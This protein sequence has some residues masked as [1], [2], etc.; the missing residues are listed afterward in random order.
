MPYAD[1]EEKKARNRAY[2]A[3]N[4]ERILAQQRE[5]YAETAA[6]A[7][8]QR[9]DYYGR[10]REQAVARAKRWRLGNRERHNA[11][12]RARAHQHREGRRMREAARRARQRGAF[13]EDV[14]PLVVLER[15]DGAC[16]ICGGDVDPHDFHV[17]HIDPL[18]QGGLHGYCN[19]QLA[20]PTC[21][22]Q[23]GSK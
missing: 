3:A 17:D 18:A 12:C 2:Y 4:R 16:G 8:A 20:H 6:T 21:N 22:L 11:L 15:D 13:L 23:K 14:H 10:T 7:R 5:H 9:R 1:P 19:V